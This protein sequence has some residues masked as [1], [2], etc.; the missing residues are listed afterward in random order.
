MQGGRGGRGGGHRGGRGGFQ[1]GRPQPS[2]GKNKPDLP[3][4][5][6]DF[7]TENAKF[8]KMISEFGVRFQYFFK[9]L[10]QEVTIPIMMKHLAR[11]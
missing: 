4:N 6:Y 3:E 11:F 10:T 8:K 5:D 1:P 7:E 9:N 2:A